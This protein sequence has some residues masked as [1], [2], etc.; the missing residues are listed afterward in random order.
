MMKIMKKRTLIMKRRN[1]KFLLMT[2]KKE[3][4]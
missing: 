1:H 2:K 4:S 3:K